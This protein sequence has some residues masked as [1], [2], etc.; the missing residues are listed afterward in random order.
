[1]PV[2]RGEVM[3][4]YGD[5]LCLGRLFEAPL[6]AVQAVLSLEKDAWSLRMLPG[7]VVISGS[8]SAG[9]R[10]GTAGFSVI[11]HLPYSSLSIAA[12]I[13]V[14][15]EVDVSFSHAQWSFKMECRV[16]KPDPTL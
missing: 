6:R 9:C 2:D 1:M 8:I 15:R 11:F 7:D 3:G 14:L 10:I 16:R 12:G 5:K 13:C 4:T